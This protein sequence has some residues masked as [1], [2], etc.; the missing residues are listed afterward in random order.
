[1]RSRLVGVLA[2]LLLTGCGS[3]VDGSASPGGTATSS[4]TSS[5]TSSATATATPRPTGEVGGGAR[6]T[7]E[8]SPEPDPTQE[9]P[10]LGPVDVVCAPY[11]D[12]V[13][14]FDAVA[15]SGFPGGL[16]TDFGPPEAL[17]WLD[18][19]VYDV[20]ARCGYQVVVDIA[21]EYPEEIAPVITNSAVVALEEV[22]DL[23]EGQLCRDLQDRGLTAQDAVDYW[24]LW[25]QPTAMDADANGVPC[26]T[27]FPDAAVHLPAWY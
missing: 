15:A 22:A 3:T 19:V 18:A 1:M 20:V 8:P 2:A 10:A 11:E 12:A 17:A 23:P 21:A 24:F 7:P 4:T 16:V 27:V 9:T 26:E 6:P 5:A 14:T 25:Q 13:D